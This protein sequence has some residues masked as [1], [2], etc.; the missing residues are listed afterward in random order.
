MSSTLNHPKKRRVSEIFSIF[1]NLSPE[2]KELYSQT[3]R[4]EILKKQQN[5][6]QRNKMFK[7]SQSKMKKSAEEILPLKSDRLSSKSNSRRSY[8][9]NLSGRLTSSR[10]RSSILQP[11]QAIQPPDDDDLFEQF[12]NKYKMETYEKDIFRKYNY[13]NLELIY[14]IARLV[15]EP[16]DK[17]KSTQINF[18]DIIDE[19][20]NHTSIMKI[21]IKKQLIIKSFG[22]KYNFY[23]SPTSEIIDEQNYKEIL[24][25]YDT[26][27]DLEYNI[28][29]YIEEAR[30]NFVMKSTT[31]QVQINESVTTYNKYKYCSVCNIYNH[32][33]Y[34]LQKCTGKTVLL[35]DLQN[36]AG[37][38][39][40]INDKLKQTEPNYQTLANSTPVNRFY[41]IDLILTIIEK[42][43]KGKIFPI[44]FTN[45]FVTTKSN[46]SKTETKSINIPYICED[47][48]CLLNS[49]ENAGEYDDIMLIITI[50]LLN[51]VTNYNITFNCFSYDSYKWWFE[52]DRPNNFCFVELNDHCNFVPKIFTRDYQLLLMSR[53]I[54]EHFNPEDFISQNTLQFKKSGPSNLT[55]YN[56]VKHV[57]NIARTSKSSPS[58][59]NGKSRKPSSVSTKKKRNILNS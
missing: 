29:T 15:I 43:Y 41:I 7:R 13:Q 20:F 35:I 37:L 10:R 47:N 14:E 52:T 57:S 12:C 16:N 40:S 18:D 56:M 8:S 2:E 1:Q 42:K 33:P 19:K 24:Y 48:F 22:D 54:L 31:T 3:E 6:F 39:R 9:K 49:M 50:I 27:L 36:I 26:S 28:N 44:F 53:P 51:I 32:L 25:L 4:D 58:P 59:I 55:E 21:F 11:I 46:G 17:Y 38:G 5:E 34:L 30:L 23:Y 45:N